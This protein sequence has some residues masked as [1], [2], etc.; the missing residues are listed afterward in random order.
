MKNALRNHYIAG[1][2]E[3]VTD[4]LLQHYYQARGIPFGDK[5]GSPESNTDCMPEDERAEFMRG[6]NDH[7]EGRYYNPDNLDCISRLD[8]Q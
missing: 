1:W 4:L 7:K 6:W 8:K 3:C 5:L 2:R